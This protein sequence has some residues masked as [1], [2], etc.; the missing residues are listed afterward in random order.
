MYRERE[1]DFQTELIRIRDDED[2]VEHCGAYYQ[3]MYV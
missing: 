2:R 3:A 1:R